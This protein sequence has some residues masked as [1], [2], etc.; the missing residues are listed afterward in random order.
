MKILQVGDLHL[1]YR[2]YG[3]ASRE[4][5]FINAF[6]AAMK[7]AADRKVDA[8][9]FSGDLFEFPKPA[10]PVVNLVKEQV[11][12]LKGHGIEV[13]GIEGNHDASGGAWLR[14]C[15]I[16]DL[17]R[18]PVSITRG[19]ETVVFSGMSYVREPLFMEE[20]KAALVEMNRGSDFFFM[21]QSI[22]EAAPFTPISGV[23]LA[24]LLKP[25]G[26]KYVGIG[27]LHKFSNYEIDGIKMYYPGSIEMTD[28]NEPRDKYVLEIDFTNNEVQ[29]VTAVK[30]P[31]RPIVQ[32]TVS[33]PGDLE[34]LTA[35]MT[36]NECS[37][38]V[39]NISRALKDSIEELKELADKNNQPIRISVFSEEAADLMTGSAPVWERDKG[40][41]DLR[42]AVQRVFEPDSDEF[43]LTLA[44]L[45]APLGTETIAKKYIE[46]KL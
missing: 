38:I 28:I 14:L 20:L 45:E 13:L 12:A 27:H 30:L 21:H 17:N 18:N 31:T 26:V 5:D 6:L 19:K 22:L 3:L 8:V 7:T 23:E 11:S 4:Q 41:L 44:M 46:E 15:G 36:D 25:R 2:Q 9:V 24:K 39:V 1:D 35:L 42:T 10:G 37:L 40:I 33:T 32:Y 34:K 16:T 29:K 43:S